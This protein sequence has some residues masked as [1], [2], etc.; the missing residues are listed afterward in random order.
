VNDHPSVDQLEMYAANYENNRMTLSM[1]GLL[2]P[3]RVKASESLLHLIGCGDWRDEQILYVRGCLTGAANAPERTTAEVGLQFAF[4]LY[5]TS[6]VAVESLRGMD[7]AFRRVSNDGCE[8][9]ARRSHLLGDL[10]GIAQ[11]KTHATSAGSLDRCSPLRSVDPRLADS[12]ALPQ[13]LV[14]GLQ[15]R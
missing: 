5:F 8:I 15:Q 13:G 1:I 11:G 3:S 4:R 14:H 10:Q 6:Y 7:V 2:A 9:W 12:A